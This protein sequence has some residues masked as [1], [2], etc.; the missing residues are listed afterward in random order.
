MKT[1]YYYDPEE[2]VYVIESDGKEYITRDKCNYEPRPLT[3]SGGIFDYYIYGAIRYLVLKNQILSHLDWRTCDGK[4]F[5]RVCE[6]EGAVPMRLTV[7]ACKAENKIIVENADTKCIL[8]YTIDPWD[9]GDYE[10]YLDF[11]VEVIA[12]WSDDSESYDG[13]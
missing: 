4:F 9:G 10:H 2:Q 11:W 1:N 5:L 12:Q 8:T 6:K 13:E 7:S 3:V